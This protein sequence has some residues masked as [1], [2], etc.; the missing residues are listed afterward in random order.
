MRKFTLLTTATILSAAVLGSQGLTA[1]AASANDIALSACEN[2]YQIST[3]GNGVVISNDL[4]KLQGI[5]DKTGVDCDIESILKECL[6]NLPNIELP[7]IG[8]PENKP[9]NDKPDTETPD[10][11]TPDTDLPDNNAPGTPDVPDNDKPGAETPDNRPETENQA[12]INRVV[13][14][15]NIERA[16]E[17]LAPLSVDLN[18]QAA[19]QIRAL[20]IETSFSHTRPNGSSFST[21][22]KEQN[23]SYRTAGENIAWG[24]R[25]PEEVVIGWMNSPGHR[26]NIMNSGFTKIGVG[27]HQNTRGTNYWSQLFI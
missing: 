2:G 3:Y 5:L 25:S 24:Q 6:E 16:K 14:L 12:Y 7:G 10:I 20:E 4:S 26:A 18:V 1:Q 17:G 23:V 21:A 22:L 11:D 9:D 13:E 8:T 15:V 27:Y 19:A